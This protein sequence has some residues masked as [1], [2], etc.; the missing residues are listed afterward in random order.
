MFRLLT[1]LVFAGVSINA[2][3]ITT[4]TF[5]S[6]ANQFSIVF[7]EIGNP[8]NT[9]GMMVVLGIVTLLGLGVKRRTL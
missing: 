6:G 1:V 4:E 2:Q 7:V 8:G 3:T 5:G 9:A